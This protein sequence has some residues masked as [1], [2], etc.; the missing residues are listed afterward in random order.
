MPRAMHSYYLRNMYLENNLVKPN[1][2]T[3]LGEPLD[4]DRVD[5]I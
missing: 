5:P 4:L 2:L 1:C 3:L